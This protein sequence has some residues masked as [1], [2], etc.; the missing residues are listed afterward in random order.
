MPPHTYASKLE[1][2]TEISA[3]TPVPDAGLGAGV[4]VLPPLL[5]LLELLFF[6]LLLFLL[7]LAG[8]AVEGAGFFTSSLVSL[9]MVSTPTYH[10]QT[11]RCVTGSSLLHL[12]LLHHNSQLHWKMANSRICLTAAVLW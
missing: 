3:E 11:D 12:P 4:L 9:A 2:A 1:D 10:L 5:P 8:A 6:P 7:P